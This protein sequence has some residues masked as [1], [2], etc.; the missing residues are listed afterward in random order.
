MDIND[1]HFETPHYFFFPFHFLGVSNLLQ[2]CRNSQAQARPI[3]NTITHH[4]TFRAY[5]WKTALN[6]TQR[7]TT[8]HLTTT[9]KRFHQSLAF[10]TASSEQGTSSQSLCIRGSGLRRSCWWNGFRFDS[11]SK[12]VD[13]KQ[14]GQRIRGG[15]ESPHG[16]HARMCCCYV[17]DETR[18]FR[19]RISKVVSLH[20]Y[21]GAWIL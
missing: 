3:I 21:R 6:T 15:P 9:H 1:S 19:R 4:K 7:S 5:R 10:H 2:S 18:P 20:M 16:M 17:C 12:T 14:K 11:E 13:V 8:T